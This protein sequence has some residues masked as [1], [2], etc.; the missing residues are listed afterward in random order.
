VRSRNICFG[1]VPVAIRQG[2]RR[3]AA[4]TGE[5]RHGRCA[6]GKSTYI[7]LYRNSG[8]L[9]LEPMR[10]R[11]ARVDGR[12][13]TAGAQPLAHV[14]TVGACGKQNSA[15]VS[16]A[17]A[18]G[19]RVA[20]CLGRWRTAH[21]PSG[22]HGTKYRSLNY[23][24]GFNSFSEMSTFRGLGCSR[25]AVAHHQSRTSHQNPECYVQSSS[26]FCWTP[27]VV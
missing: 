24:V 23:H 15:W 9:A 18:G 2:Q 16:G 25:K 22:R 20:T 6:A 17:P 8:K 13:I 14:Y 12:S 21:C 1:H 4:A 19:R 7:R 27:P 26:G 10:L 5:E 11:R 3:E